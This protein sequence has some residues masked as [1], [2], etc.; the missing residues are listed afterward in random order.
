MSLASGPRAARLVQRK[1]GYN[2]HWSTGIAS[3][4][5]TLNT[6]LNETNLW[7]TASLLTKLSSASSPTLKYG[8][9]SHTVTAINCLEEPS[10]GG[11]SKSS[12]NSSR[13]MLFASLRDGIYE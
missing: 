13:G 4:R 12:F 7:H 1:R 6:T 9:T 2:R 3:P 8:G 5:L 10:V 11:D